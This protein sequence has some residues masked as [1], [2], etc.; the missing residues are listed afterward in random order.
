MRLWI[1]LYL[2]QLPLDV[3]SPLWSDDTGCVVL[4]QG[5]VLACSPMAAAA[6]I[7][8][9]MR[10]GGAL[11]LLPQARVVERDPGREAAAL[12]AVALALLQYTPLVTAAEDAS[13]LLDVG[14]SLRLF[15]GVRALC[16]RV[17]ASLAAL[18][19]RAALAC[20]PTARGAWLLARCG[21][22][23]VLRLPSLA[24]RLDALPS[25]ALPPARPQLLWL[26]GIGCHS[27]GQLRRLPR[28][29]LQRRAGPAL[30]DML[31]CAYGLAPE[32]FTWIVPPAS[33]RARLEL[34]DRIEQ[35]ELLLAGA[36]HLLQ[37]LCGWLC[38]RQLAVLGVRLALE[39]ERGRTACPPTLLEVALAEPTWHEEHLLRLLK[40]KLGRQ[41]LDAPVIALCLEA[42]RVQ[43]AVLPSGL[44]FPEPGGSPED[45]RQLF[46]LLAA[47][48]GEDQVLQPLPQADYRP[49]LAN[50]WVPLG[51]GASARTA[52]AGLPPPARA[53]PRPVWLLAQP[54]ALLLRGHRPFY[55]S[56]L[57]LV[58]A[59]ERIEAGWWNGTQTRDYFV[60]RGDDHALYWIYRERI[61]AADGLAAPR[62]FLHGLFA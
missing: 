52:A 23:R 31:D 60:A 49:E 61:A 3:F 26:E 30:L 7:R 17:R 19:L 15:G 21:G 62:W 50:A 6:G 12:E 53:L 32:L 8:P 43:A 5:R 40:E 42:P 10:Q 27:L 57:Q 41:R 36:A 39:H 22:A 16:R 48:L 25:G 20:A 4:E 11:M 59:P 45:Q 18:G 2:S 44:L 51:S 29:G 1:G 24:R 56:P 37:Q 35:A 9:G 47:R 13:L 54:V 46:E 34:F 38:A 28:A 58:S 33:F 55:G 14:A